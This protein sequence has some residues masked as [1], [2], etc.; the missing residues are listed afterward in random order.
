MTNTK[1][2]LA[3]LIFIAIAAAFAFA[4]AGYP[5]GTAFQMGPGYFPLF[6]SAF[7][8]L[9]GT[10]ITINGLRSQGTTI[11]HIRGRSFVLLLAPIFFGLTVRGLGLVPTVA[12]V[13]LLSAFATRTVRIGTAVLSAIMISAVCYLIFV[14]GLG[15]PLPALG[16]W[17]RL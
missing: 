12:I 11:G 6:L 5:L 15:M 8:G 16:P 9:L 17:L 3:G 13:V 1:D 7:L 4:S 10:A 14:R 2:L